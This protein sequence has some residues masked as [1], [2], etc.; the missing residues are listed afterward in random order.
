MARGALQ[1]SRADIAVAVT[2]I[3]G[4]GGGSLAKPVGLVHFGL[5]QRPSA[6]RTVECRFG[7]LGRDAVRLASV[8]QALSLLEEALGL[9]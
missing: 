6:L 7:D 1:M 8:D 9:A 2:G 5:A 3:A 4:P